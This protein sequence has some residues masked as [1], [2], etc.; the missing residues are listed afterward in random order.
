MAS[1]LVPDDDAGA[2]S[3][4]SLA[5]Q[6]PLSR[7]LLGETLATL[8][9]GVK[10][11]AAEGITIYVK[12]VFPDPA[13]PGHMCQL[14]RSLGCRSDDAVDLIVSRFL[15]QEPTIPKGKAYYLGY[16]QLLFREG[17]LDDC[18]ITHGKSV[19]LYAPGKTAAAYHNEGAAFVLWSLLPIVFGLASLL[20]S[21]ASVREAVD[22]SDYNAMFLFIGLLLLIPGVVVLALGLIL[23]P[24]CPMPCYFSGTDWW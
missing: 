3:A 21:V 13:N 23:I 10:K 15:A 20:F 4:G 2:R 17:T 16:D 1:P 8:T 14:S 6:S 18:G 11:Q 24:E 22:T 19:E 9:S 7:W 12:C 5:S